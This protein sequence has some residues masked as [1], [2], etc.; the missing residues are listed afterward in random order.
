MKINKIIRQRGCA[1]GACP[2]IIL[3][4]DRTVLVQG[5]KIRVPPSL[6]V[7]GHED[8]VEIPQEGFN[9]LVQEYIE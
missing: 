3:T 8:M 1:N 5:A 2:G 6:E 9:E 7:P 4:G